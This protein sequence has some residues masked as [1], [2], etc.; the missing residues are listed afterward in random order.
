VQCTA[1]MPDASP[2]ASIALTI[3]RRLGPDVHSTITPTTI[4]LMAQGNK[5][6]HCGCC[7]MTV[8]PERREEEQ[9]QPTKGA[10]S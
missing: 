3:P 1:R 5:R 4:E 8:I 10:W 2:V 7:A 6:A 9:C